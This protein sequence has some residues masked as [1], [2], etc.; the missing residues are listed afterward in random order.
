VLPEARGQG[1]QRRLI[2]ARERHARALGM[3]WLVTD[4]YQNPASS[5]SLIAA[6]YRLYEPAQPWG[7]RGTLY[8]R[9][10]LADTSPRPKPRLEDR[11]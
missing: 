4:T 5:N 10:R 11:R 9:K 1:L 6:G 8:W 7:A 2:G 3:A